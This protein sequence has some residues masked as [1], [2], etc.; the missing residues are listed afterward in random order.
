MA[1][2]VRLTNA[3]RVLDVPVTSD[4]TTLRMPRSVYQKLGSL[5]KNKT[6]LADYLANKLSPEYAKIL[7]DLGVLYDKKYYNNAL[8]VSV[9]IVA[10]DEYLGALGSTEEYPYDKDA[11]SIAPWV[12]LDSRAAYRVLSTSNGS[13]I[14]VDGAD[15]LVI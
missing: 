2:K 9:D 13:E 11:Q 6:L 10:L 3:S 8:E 4:A 15:I 12:G 1:L 7:Y 5:I 14:L